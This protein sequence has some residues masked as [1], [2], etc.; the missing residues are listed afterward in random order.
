MPP[1]RLR[2]TRAIATALE[3]P[4]IEGLGGVESAEGVETAARRIERSAYNHA[5]ISSS[6]SGCGAEWASRRFATKYE[7]YAVYCIRNA[8]EM[9]ALVESGAEK[10]RN[11][12]A[13]SSQFLH[14]DVWEPLVSEKT[15]R[16]QCADSGSRVKANTT[17][18]A[19]GRCKSKECYFYELQTRSADEPMTVFVTCLDCGHRWRTG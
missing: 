11:I 18:L 9:A 14:P 19:C 6:V 2:V 5:V 15:A 17:A 16:D 4:G 1:V 12:A 3:R 8:R 13:C 7:Q 10:P